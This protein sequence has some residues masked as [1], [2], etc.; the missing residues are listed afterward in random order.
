MQY[1][2]QQNF[3]ML[4]T[5]GY[6]NGPNTY[7][8]NNNA[9]GQADGS[10]PRPF[11]DGAQA[12]TTY[13]NYVCAQYLWQ[14]E[15]QRHLLAAAGRKPSRRKPAPARRPL[16]AE[17]A[18]RPTGCNGTTTTLSPQVC[19]AFDGSI[20]PNSAPVLTGTVTTAGNR[21]R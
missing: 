19:I 1:S 8:L 12:V 2:C 6:W 11:D 16:P 18:R 10:A 17:A 14:D 3:T 20:P 13:T 15:R 21:G 7:D 5:D 9:V 4:S